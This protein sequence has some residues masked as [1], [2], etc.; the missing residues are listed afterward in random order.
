MKKPEISI[1]VP[2]YN[3]ATRLERCIESILSQ[4]FA[5]FELILVNDGS[6]DDSAEICNKFA[7]FDNRIHVVHRSKNGGAS[8]A[9]NDCV[10]ASTG[11][12]IGWVDADDYI[13]KEMFEKLHKAAKKYNSDITECGI[14][15]LDNNKFIIRNTQKNEV[16]G[17]GDFIA[18]EFFSARMLPSLCTKLYKRELWK[19]MFFPLG[20]NHQDSIVNTEFA[21]WNLKYARIPD[22]LYYYCP[23][24]NSITTAVSESAIRQAI[25]MFDIKRSLLFKYQLSAEKENQLKFDSLNKMILRYYSLT[26]SKLF[27]NQRIYNRIIL[28]RIK[29]ELPAYLLDKRLIWP[30]KINYI[31]TLLNLL[32]LKI[33][34]KKLLN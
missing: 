25:H 30:T 31:L 8:A 23:I 29:H 13:D 12:Y 14:F 24:E 15:T 2:V 34:I 27:K 9:R 5:D 32:Y 1:L 21:L 18:N 11:S 6:S 7:S 19:D 4:T 28:G 17:E 20:R 16:F 26:S 3:A 22:A 10:R 33:N